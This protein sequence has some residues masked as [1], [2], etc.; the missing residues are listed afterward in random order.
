[1]KQ[2]IHTAI[3]W[4]SYAELEAIL[5]SNGFAIGYNDGEQALRDVVRANVEDGTIPEWT[6]LS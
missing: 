2:E 5:I 1:M 3:N 4:L 6:V